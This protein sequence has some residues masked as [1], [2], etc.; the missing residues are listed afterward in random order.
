MLLATEF[1]RSTPRGGEDDRGAWRYG[2]G[3]TAAS[4][5]SSGRFTPLSHFDG[6]RYQAGPVFPDPLRGHAM[7]LKTGGHPGPRGNAAIRRW[8]SPL[9]GVV[10]IAGQ[11]QHLSD[12]GDG[13]CGRIVSGDGT[14][15]GEWTAF[16]ERIEATVA[17]V[18]VKKG[19]VLDF[20]VDCR[21]TTMADSF[22]WAPVVTAVS[23]PGTTAAS[24][25]AQADF[26][27]PPPPLLTPWEQ[28]AQALLLT[29]EFWFVD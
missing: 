11:L 2:C 12:K 19:D 23:K 18:P 13:I 15:L 14:G 7:L 29:N 16:N 8:V 10:T 26:A 21:E 25:N 4:P 24:W 1:V 17:E 28:C 6:Q 27:G 22:S 5:G 20:V 3:D 9:D